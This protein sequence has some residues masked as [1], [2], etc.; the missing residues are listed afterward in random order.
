MQAAMCVSAL[1]VQSLSA[2]RVAARSAVPVRCVAQP[3]SG[4]KA[5]AA[6]KEV[7][8]NSS[9][10]PREWGGL[11]RLSGA[12]GGS[13]PL[14]A[15]AVRCQESNGSAGGRHRSFSGAAAAAAA[16]SGAAI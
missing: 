2:R 14:Q 10:A 5:A 7:N 12:C 16:P 1:R 13:G 6:K 8:L 4:R 15:I 11:C 3:N 9:L